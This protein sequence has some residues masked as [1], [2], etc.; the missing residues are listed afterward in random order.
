MAQDTRIFLAGEGRL[1]AQPCAHGLG[2][3]ARATDEIGRR[4]FAVTGLALEENF[5]EIVPDSLG[6]KLVEPDLDRAGEPGIR[7]LDRRVRLNEA[8]RAWL[9]GVRYS[10]G[11]KDVL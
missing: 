7:L 1:S 10:T 9:V 8:A 5:E 11:K 6:S 4:G 3:S 2:D